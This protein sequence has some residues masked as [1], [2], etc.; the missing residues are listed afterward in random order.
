ML[1]G[2]YAVSVTLQSESTKRLGLSAPLVLVAERQHGLV[3]GRAR[4]DQQRV[5]GDVGAGHLGRE[6]ARGAR[7]AGVRL[8]RPE[9][10]GGDPEGAGEARDVVRGQRAV[11]DLRAG[12]GV[13]GELAR[14]DRRRRRCR[15]RRR[16][17]SAISA[18]P[19]DARGELGRRD[20]A[21]RRRQQRPHGGVREVALGQRAVPDLGAAHRALADVGAVDEL[22]RLGRARRGRRRARAARRAWRRRDDARRA[23]YERGAVFKDSRRTYDGASAPRR[24][25][26]PG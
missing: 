12:H 17:P 21:V 14:A 25:A 22:A 7:P 6:P 2:V 23:P 3:E 5:L 19:N 16:V 11:G 24:L 10:L 26:S 15:P 13:V 9:V 20:R 4:R 8:D 1:G 18:P